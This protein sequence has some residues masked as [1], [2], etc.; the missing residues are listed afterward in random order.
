MGR[1]ASCEVHV[2][3]SRGTSD[4]V[5]RRF[6]AQVELASDEIIVRGKEGFRLKFKELSAI[7][8]KGGVLSLVDEK[9]KVELH[10]GKD[11]LL[12][13]ERAR[14]PP[15]RLDKLGIKSKVRVALLGPLPRDLREEIASSGA[16][17]VR[18]GAVDLVLLTPEARRDLAQLETLKEWI[19]PSGAV[20]VIRER[21]SEAVTERDMRA[22]AREAGL[23]A[24][25]VAK[26]SETHTADKLV[27]PRRDR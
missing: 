8:A 14:S 2:T 15:G 21:G 7:G 10:L 18:G 1:E 24:I 5:E 12:W 6:K 26:L 23:V 13:A 16:V 19:A 27:I 17:E 22:A 20:W 4:P 25:K 11:T 9:R 3:T